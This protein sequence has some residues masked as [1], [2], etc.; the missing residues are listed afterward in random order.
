[1]ISVTSDKSVALSIS[2][3]YLVTGNNV[4]Y[5]PTPAVETGEKASGELLNIENGPLY[6]K[7]VGNSLL[8]DQSR[9]EFEVGGV[10]IHKGT[11]FGIFGKTPGTQQ[12]VKK[13]ALTANELAS[14]LALSGIVAIEP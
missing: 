9:G 14:A 4:K 12:T 13:A 10:F 1:M 11:K 7:S 6:V 5:G 2:V 3:Q 8:Y